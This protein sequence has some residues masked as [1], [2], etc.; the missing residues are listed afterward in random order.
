[1]FHLTLAWTRGTSISLRVWN[2][3]LLLHRQAREAR[4]WVKVEA[5]S[6]KSILQ[7]P[8]DMST[9][10]HYRLTLLI[11]L[12]YRV[13][14]SSHTF[15]KSVV[16]ILMHHIHAYY[17][18]MCERLSFKVETLENPRYVSETLGTRVSVDLIC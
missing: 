13:R 9:M 12:I 4:V 15:D 2:R 8:K 3:H 16:Q 10:W 14:F 1:M 5:R 17:C 18:I 11:S 6:S 7:G